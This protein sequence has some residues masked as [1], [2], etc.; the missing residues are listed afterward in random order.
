[1]HSLLEHS[2]STTS[3]SSPFLGGSTITSSAFL[4]KG[5]IFAAARDS[6]FTFTLLD[7]SLRDLWKQST[8]KG[9][10][11]ELVKDRQD[12]SKCNPM[13]PTPPY[14]STHLGFSWYAA[15]R[16]LDIRL[17]ISP[18]ASMLPCR[19]TVGGKCKGTS[20]PGRNSLV[21]FLF[22]YLQSQLPSS[23]EIMA[24]ECFHDPLRWTHK[25]CTLTPY[26]DAAPMIPLHSPSNSSL[27]WVPF[28]TND[29][30]TLPEL[31]SK[32]KRTNRKLPVPASSSNGFTSSSRAILWT[33]SAALLMSTWWASLVVAETRWWDPFWKS[34]SVSWLS[35]LRTASFASV[36]HPLV[37]PKMTGNL[38]FF[39]AK[40][41]LAFLTIGAPQGL[42]MYCSDGSRRSFLATFAF[43]CLDLRFLAFL[44]CVAERVGLPLVT[45]LL[46]FLTDLP[47]EENSMMVKVVSAGKTFSCPV[48]HGA[49][50]Q[51]EWAPFHSGCSIKGGS[52][53]LRW[54]L[55]AIW[56]LCLWLRTLGASETIARRPPSTPR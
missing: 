13:V 46:C 51:Q 17:T 37:L 20:C 35:T 26:L 56:R 25:E 42:R 19:K 7:V 15:L 14:S 2:A 53:A 44:S 48:C 45:S 3:S 1:M 36:L 16:W 22:P 47:M 24:L 52:R 32:E 8:L 43:F 29:I 55:W 5:S 18:K 11:S 6:Y 49:Y 31:L 39:S 54:S 28:H 12:F 21:P 50:W 10:S 23:C 40:N 41:D 38:I 33:K 34:P 30:W 9:F 27:F 4:R